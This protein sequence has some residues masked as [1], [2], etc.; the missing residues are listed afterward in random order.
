M[1]TSAALHA[2]V[3][4][5]TLPRRQRS[6]AVLV[7]NDVDVPWAIVVVV[8]VIVVVIVTCATSS[9]AVAARALTAASSSLYRN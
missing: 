7:G 3:G 9:T 2:H 1:L 8:V 6:P 4:H 5:P